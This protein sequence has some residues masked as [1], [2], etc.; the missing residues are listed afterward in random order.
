MPLKI[1]GKSF[2]LTGKSLLLTGV[3]CLRSIGLVFILP[4]EIRFGLVCL[5]WKI[6]LVFLLT[7]RPRPEI[8]FGILKLTVPPLKVKKTNRK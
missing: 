8:R 1:V 6:G 5:R 3:G 7:V 4:V 2:L